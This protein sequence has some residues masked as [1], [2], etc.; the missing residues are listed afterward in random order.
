MGHMC[1]SSVR[2]NEGLVLRTH[3]RCTQKTKPLK[4]KRG[5]QI[6]SRGPILK[7]TAVVAL[8]I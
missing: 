6:K 5:S 7:A 2:I 4:S 3:I 1:H 8:R